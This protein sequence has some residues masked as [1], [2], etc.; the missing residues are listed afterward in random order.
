MESGS[1]GTELYYYRARYYRPDLG[2]FTSKDPLGMI[3]GTN[4]FIYVQNDPVIFSDPFDKKAEI[5]CR[6]MG[7]F[8]KGWVFH[9]EQ[10]INHLIHNL[11]L[12]ITSQIEGKL[13]EWN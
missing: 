13:Y 7:V 1:N 3:D 6:L 8:H 2:R 9:Q 5:C 10:K 12:D 4:M 11:I